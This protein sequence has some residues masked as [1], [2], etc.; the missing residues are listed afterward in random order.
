MERAV[1]VMT[2]KN[3]MTFI[4]EGRR[5]DNI[6]PQTIHMLTTSGQVRKKFR[7]IDFLLNCCI[8][9]HVSPIGIVLNPK[10]AEVR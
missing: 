2:S 7:I 6:L 1:A 10:G 8:S 4:A 5:A 9:F 3:V